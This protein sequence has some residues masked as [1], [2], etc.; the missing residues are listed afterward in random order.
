MPALQQFHE[1]YGDQV[2]VLGIDFIDTQPEAALD[3]AQRARAPPTRRSP[4]RRARC[5]S[6]PTCASA[7]GCPQFLLLDADG[8][9]D[10]AS[11]PAA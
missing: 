6:E 3:L 5:R 9:V 7:S 10:P 2:A 8:A 4:T 1:R 11:R